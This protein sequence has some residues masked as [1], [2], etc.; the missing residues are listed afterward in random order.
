MIRLQCQLLQFWRH[1]LKFAT[2]LLIAR[3]T[4]RTISTQPRQTGRLRILNRGLGTRK[5]TVQIWINHGP[6]SQREGLFI[7]GHFRPIQRDRL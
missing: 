1:A 3:Q 5:F 6:S 2:H 7:L 4:A